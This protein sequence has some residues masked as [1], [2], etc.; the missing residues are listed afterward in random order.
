M[1]AEMMDERAMECEECGEVEC[2][3]K[4]KEET[5][6]E[7]IGTV[8]TPKDVANMVRKDPLAT[9][10]L[11]HGEVLWGHGPVRSYWQGAFLHIL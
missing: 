10:V 9:Y 3:T 11:F 7:H 2:K 1:L 5:I 6:M 4:P 8:K